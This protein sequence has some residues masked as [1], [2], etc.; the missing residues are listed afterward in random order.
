M[1]NFEKKYRITDVTKEFNGILLR[2]IENIATNRYGGWVGGEH[3]LS[4]D[5]SCFIYNE[6]MV[7]GSGR[8]SGNASI[9]DTAIVC[10]SAIVT[11]D[12][13]V[14]GNAIIDGS[15]ILSNNDHV[16]NRWDCIEH[17][18]LLKI[19]IQ[20][21][22]KENKIYANGKNQ[23]PLTVN[24]NAISKGG[25][26]I[27]IESHEIFKNIKFVDYKNE[28]FHG[29]VFFN[30]KKGEY[31]YPVI[32]SSVDNNFLSLCTAYAS[33]DEL[34]EKFNISVQCTV[35]GKE[36]TTSAL[37]NNGNMISDYITLFPL[38][39]RIFANSNIETFVS[40]QND[41]GDGNIILTKYYVRFNPSQGIET[42]NATCAENYTYQYKQKGNHN[43]ANTSTDKL[44]N[45]DPEA[46]FTKEYIFPQGWSIFI[47][48]KNHETTGLCFWNCQIEYEHFSV[49]KEWVVEM[50]F[51]LIDQY[52]NKANLASKV[53]S[54]G[55]VIFYVR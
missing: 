34:V 1:E 31:V 9:H 43:E 46:I 2:R 6:A 16:N 8:V 4:Q 39:K 42:K 27:K 24:L 47:T 25:K 14:S 28:I 26:E 15:I 3:N 5:G 7:Y 30:E 20:G 33:L 55:E 12:A 13:M 35:N 54:N 48:A 10:D 41:L 37:N 36:Y 49:Y 11:D 23:I 53:E 38:P 17:L 29:D 19:N 22:S 21:G 50:D 40:K 45:Y 44:V 52:G 32:Y 51:S 18:N